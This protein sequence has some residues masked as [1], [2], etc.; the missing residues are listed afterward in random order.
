MRPR[1]ATLAFFLCLPLAAKTP[2]QEVQVTTT[3]RVDF[4]PGGTI[5]IS[6]QMGELD[7]QGW[8]TPAVE[9][10]VTK[11]T[12]SGDTSKGKDQ[13]AEILKRVQVKTEK[14]G[15]GELDIVTTFPSRNLLVRPLLGRTDVTMQYVIRVPRNSHVVV[16]QGTG[17]LRLEG[18][19]GAI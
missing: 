3:D 1:L 8:D 9:I 15:N 14:K 19:T 17:D 18:L 10:T 16:H 7:V 11:S 12:W 2:L 4:A 5:H 6:G 13:G